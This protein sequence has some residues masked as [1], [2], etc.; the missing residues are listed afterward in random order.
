VIVTKSTIKGDKI[1]ISS[2]ENFYW[3]L[4]ASPTRQFT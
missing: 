1:S 4:Q 3:S 2:G